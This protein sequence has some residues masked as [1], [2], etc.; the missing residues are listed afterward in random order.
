MDNMLLWEKVSKTNPAHTKKVT[1]GR[2]I[3]A[4]DP[5]RQVENAT[6]EFGP[7]GKGWGWEVMRVENLPTNEMGILVRLWHGSPETY[8]EQWGQAS[9]FIDK[10]EKKK[11]TD[12][13]KKATTDGVTKCLSYLGFNADIFLGK[14][15]DNKYVQE[16]QQE[17]TMAEVVSA[18]AESIR[19]IKEGIEQNQ[20]STAAEAW[21]ELDDS[22]KQWLWV[23]PSLGGCFTTKERDIMKSKEFKDSHYGSTE[24]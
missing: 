16:R 2:A 9:L 10:A 21:F 5:Y 18:N 23:A 13:F 15:D 22:T 4:V 7:A 20:L 1:F 19:V 12:C 3:T 24:D 8:I 14:F 11:D 17:V 6:R